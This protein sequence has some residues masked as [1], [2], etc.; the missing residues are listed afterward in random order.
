MECEI[1]GRKSDKLYKVQVENSFFDV[2]ANCKKHGELVYEES[3]EFKNTQKLQKS[4]QIQRV[5][6]VLIENYGKVIQAARERKGLTRTDLA[7]AIN[8]QENYLERVE[9]QK[10]LPDEKLIHKLEKFLGINLFEEQEIEIPLEKKNSKNQGTYLGDFLD[11]ED[12]D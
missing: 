12:E 5:E 11:Q 4:V 10:T 7:R 6:K 1:C 3:Q 8:E 9:K 2:C